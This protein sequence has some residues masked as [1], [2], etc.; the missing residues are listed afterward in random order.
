VPHLAPGRPRFHAME[1]R[2]KLAYNYGSRNAARLLARCFR[3]W[4]I[5]I[6]TELN[7]RLL[8]AR[9]AESRITFDQYASAL[10]QREQEQ[11][12]MAKR[13]ERRV[14]K[15]RLRLQLQRCFT[16]WLAGTRDAK[17]RG[18]GVRTAGRVTDKVYFTFQTSIDQG[19]LANCYLLW[20]AQMMTVLQTETF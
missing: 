6:V 18:A 17:L 9:L 19:L 10:K 15:V 20:S 14:C 3:C 8:Q 13:C 4:C 1:L 2:A 16:R 7:E 12:V 5:C 11:Y